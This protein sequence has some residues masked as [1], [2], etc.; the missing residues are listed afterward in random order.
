MLHFRRLN[1][2][3]LVVVTGK[4][5]RFRISLRQHNL[6]V[7]RRSVADVALLVGERRMLKPCHQF[8]SGRLMWIVALQAIRFTKRLV[9]M[10]LL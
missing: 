7:F 2:L 3:R 9:L 4:A 8:R 10:C 5:E 6:S 1:Q